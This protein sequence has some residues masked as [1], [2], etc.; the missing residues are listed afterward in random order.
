MRDYEYVANALMRVWFPKK[1]TDESWLQSE[2]GRSWSEI[3]L[4]DA[5]VAVDAYKE[6]LDQKYQ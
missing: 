6:F 2:D 5:Q 4:L 3:S 1:H